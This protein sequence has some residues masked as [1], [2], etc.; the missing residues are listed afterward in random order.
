MRRSLKPTAFVLLLLTSIPATAR[1]QVGISSVKDPESKEKAVHPAPVVPWSEEKLKELL[2]RRVDIEYGGHKF[3]QFSNLFVVI[4][5]RT[6][7]DVALEWA[8][9]IG[10]ETSADKLKAAKVG[11]YE[12]Y[13]FEALT[14]SQIGGDVRWRHWVFIADGRGY[15]VVSTLPP[16]LEATLYPDV[17]AML[18]S[19][20]LKK[21]P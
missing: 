21:K 13:H 5:K 4:L 8:R 20:K 18:R 3:A 1:A 12:A 17:E 14:P 10:K 6:A 16:A 2:D 19:F 9:R 15:F 11:P 7:R